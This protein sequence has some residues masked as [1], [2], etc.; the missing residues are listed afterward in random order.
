MLLREDLYLPV[1]K[2]ILR[3]KLKIFK[4]RNSNFIKLTHCAAGQKIIL[5]KAHFK[6]LCQE[7]KILQWWHA[8][9][10]LSCFLAAGMASSVAFALRKQLRPV[11]GCLLE[12]AR[13]TRRQPGVAPQ[14][15][16]TIPAPPVPAAAN[17]P[18]NVAA[19]VNEAAANR[20]VAALLG[21]MAHLM[22]QQQQQQQQQGPPPASWNDG[23]D[24]NF[25]P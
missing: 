8:T 9:I 4:L 13:R 2:N 10:G 14:P 12:A 24:Y 16:A 22:G 20:D 25:Y 19:A 1:A 5:N 15:E 6:F 17:V 18:A 7:E 11:V 21:L 3:I 23:A